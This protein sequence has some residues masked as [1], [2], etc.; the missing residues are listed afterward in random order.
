MKKLLSI[1]VLGLLLSG[2]AYAECI[3]GDCKNGYGEYV[4]KDGDKYSGNFRKGKRNGKGIN[5]WSDGSRYDG[6]WLKNKI[7]GQGIYTNANGER[8]EG[9]FRKGKAHGEMT[10]YF[11]DGTIKVEVRNKGSFVRIVTSKKVIK[12]NDEVELASMINKAKNTCKTLGFEEGTEKFTDCSLKLYSQEVDNNAALEVAEQ[13]SSNSS[14]SGTMTI[15]DPVR[16]RQ[17]QIDRGM[18]MLS[19]GCTLGI[20]C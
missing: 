14:N 12:Q 11:P 5:E 1:V 17:N 10:T 8:L 7:H 2:N 18:K 4:W 15:S 3:K 16:D 13:K 20:D 6:E 9:N 19:G